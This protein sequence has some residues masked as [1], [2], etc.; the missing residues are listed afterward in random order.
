MQSSP[1]TGRLA[2]SPTGHLHL[3]HALSFL[4]AWWRARSQ[5]GRLLLRLEDLDVE[6]A[7]AEHA[8]AAVRDLEWL[9]LDWDGPVRLQSRERERIVEAAERLADAG[10]AYACVCSRGDLRALGAPQAGQ[11]EVPYPG[12]CRGRFTS[13][14]Q[15]EQATGKTAGLR[16]RVPSG[17][18]AF[19]DENYGPRAYDVAA[20]VGDF[21]ILRRNKMPS[22]QLSVVVDDHFDGVNEIVR[23][24]DLLPSTS[25]QLALGRA[26]GFATPR[27]FHA[28]LLCDEQG[29]RLAKREAALGLGELRAAGV[30]PRAIVAFV[31]R[32]LGQAD[33]ERAER[34]TPREWLPAFNAT[35]VGTEP[36]R[37]TTR[38]LDELRRAR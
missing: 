20:E 29:K 10:R 36:I 14:A 28:P 12:T 9:G 7:S 1:V 31:A 8:D 37:L 32:A 3:G 15:A 26:L 13:V 38:A 16:F 11:D 30:D 33:A 21:L 25:R 2:P 18:L 19:H 27:Y 34:L 35:A 6:R 17:P 4:L 5:G 23:G 22:Y 24:S